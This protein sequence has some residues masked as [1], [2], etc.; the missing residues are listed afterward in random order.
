MRSR[1]D[2][3]KGIA[4][5]VTLVLL[6]V[7]LLLGISSY[8]GSRLDE[9][10]A[11]NQRASS[12]SMMAAEFGASDVWE[13]V[14]PALFIEAPDP[15]DESY[16]DYMKEILSA[17][18]DWMVGGGENEPD[19]LG[20][21]VEL[22][23]TV[24]GENGQSRLENS[25]YS[26]SLSSEDDIENATEVVIDVHGMVNS[27]IVEDWGAHFSSGS[28]TSLPEAL[29][30]RRVVRLSVGVML[31][32]SLSPINLA[33][34]ISYYN[35]L[36]SQAT[37][38]GEVIDGY[39]NPAISVKSRA[40]AEAIVRNILKVKDNQSIPDDA[41]FVPFDSDD[42]D[43]GVFHDKSVISY[44]G[45]GNPVYDGNYGACTQQSSAL[46]NY[47]GGIAAQLSAPILTDERV[48]NFDTFVTAAVTAVDNVGSELSSYKEP[49]WLTGDQAKN[50]VDL[51]GLG[52]APEDFNVYFVTN[53]SQDSG[54][55]YVRPVWDDYLI[56]DSDKYV[57][58]TTG[59]EEDR[60]EKP[61]FELGGFNR[62]G[63]LIIDGDVQFNGNP[64][65]EGLIVVLGDY[66]ISGS[67]NLPFTGAIISAPY[68]VQFEAG[69]EFVNPYRVDGSLIASVVTGVDE[70]GN[71][72]YEQQG[73]GSDARVVF[74]NDGKP[75]I[76]DS[77]G[78]LIDGVPVFIGDSDV[79]Y[80][81]GQ[82]DEEG[83]PVISS[84]RK[85][86]PAGFHV[87]GGGR[88]PYNYDY[89]VIQR[90]I[91]LLSDE[92]RK[93][94]L[95]G[96]KRLDGSYEYGVKGWSEVLVPDALPYN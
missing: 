9:S 39:V 72:I 42:P 82:V 17:F 69:G 90:A 60:M 27:G 95:I 94:L 14:G 56:R 64:E 91:D 29:V 22:R 19:F 68:S 36:D 55:G 77:A 48:D 57:G 52:L 16:E 61:L 59:S 53:Q 15:G 58:H 79:P 10:M 43:Y 3:Q 32:E 21:C 89:S 83:Q 35:G 23:V 49:V 37:I 96:Q 78:G 44:D 92:A 70:E 2:K 4:L 6:V 46:C 1:H 62:K 51:G 24:Q 20:Q 28:L 11:G 5:V 65:F 75:V 41:V 71:D 88:Q 38:T 45:E 18:R 47:K 40:D 87:D 13:A 84:V 34:S 80:E 63:V 33:G 54:I 73:V 31:G 66:T 93:E 50:D 25:C 85:F 74:D 12:L 76:V 8:Q 30:A 7:A 26:V 67:G 81:W 86:D